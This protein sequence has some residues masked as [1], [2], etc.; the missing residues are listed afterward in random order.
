MRRVE[1]KLCRTSAWPNRSAS[2]RAVKPVG[3]GET[4]VLWK[5][6]AQGRKVGET[7]V[8]VGST[9]KGGETAVE[10][11]STGRGGETAVKLKKR[12]SVPSADSSAGSAPKSNNS[13]ATSTSPHLQHRKEKASV[14]GRVAAQGKGSGSTPSSLQTNVQTGVQASALAGPRSAGPSSS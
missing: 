3:A 5:L 13:V 9:G 10:G 6:E 8:E 12:F 2:A 4:P 11:G 1:E 7:A 14:F